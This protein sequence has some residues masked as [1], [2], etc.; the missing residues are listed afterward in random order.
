MDPWQ[1]LESNEQSNES[2]F[3]DNAKVE[4][5]GDKLEFEDNFEP[6]KSDKLPDSEEYLALL[7]LLIIY[8]FNHFSEFF[9]LF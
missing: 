3:N 7:G 6:P 1:S 9:F 4:S 2:W 8:T 5:P